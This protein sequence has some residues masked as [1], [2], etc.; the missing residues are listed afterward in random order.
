MFAEV[1]PEA[2]QKDTWGIYNK[3]TVLEETSEGQFLFTTG[4]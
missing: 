4:F 2:I 3:L 1:G